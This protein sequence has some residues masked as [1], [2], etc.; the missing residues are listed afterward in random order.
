VQTTERE[1][2]ELVGGL[3]IDARL[4]SQRF[5]ETQRRKGGR[6]NGENP[7]WLPEGS[8]RSIIAVALLLATLLGPYVRVS[9]P[10]AQWGLLGAVIVWYFESRRNGG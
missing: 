4:T 1:I 7:L 2:R 8:V 6:M 3:W 9:V 5:I 10:E